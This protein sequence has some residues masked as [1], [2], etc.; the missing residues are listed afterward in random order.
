[1]SF[2]GPENFNQVN[3]AE[4]SP[5]QVMKV[6]EAMASDSG[7]NV[8]TLGLGGDG[9]EGE[10]RFKLQNY[11]AEEDVF[12]G[13]QELLRFMEQLI[14]NAAVEDVYITVERNP[15]DSTPHIVVRQP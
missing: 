5:K 14:E 9:N 8:V 7:Y 15:T 2:V 4:N 11:S 3:K 10:Y 6:A 1:M 12:I 13:E